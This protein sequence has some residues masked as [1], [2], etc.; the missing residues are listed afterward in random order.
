MSDELTRATG[1]SNAALAAALINHLKRKG[2]MTGQEVADLGDEALA[3]LE[4]QQEKA[5]GLKPA[6]DLAR[7]MVEASLLPLG[8]SPR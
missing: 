4:R 2:L 3:I 7:R 8:K 6:F 5:T 1:L